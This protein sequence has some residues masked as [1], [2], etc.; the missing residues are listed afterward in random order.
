MSTDQ[1][2]IDDLCINTI[3]MLSVDAIEK[4]KSG[5]P[6]LPMGSAPMAYVLWTRHLRHNPANSKWPNRDRFV[7]SGGHGSMLLYSLLFLTG[8]DLPLA[9]IK[10]FRQWDSRTPG[11]PEMDTVGC[12]IEVTTGPLGQGLSNAV[13]LAIGEAHLAARFNREG[14]PL[15]DHY[16]YVLAS[17]GD[18]MEGVASEACSLAGHLGLGKLIVLYDDNRISLAGSTDLAFTEDTGKRFESYGWHV[19]HVGDGNDTAAIDAA[20]TA[21]KA[22]S[23]KPS[24]ILVH[25]IIGYGAPHKQGT[26]EAH[27]SPLGPKETEETK[28]ALGWPG[29][30]FFVPDEALN[31]FRQTLARGKQQE[32]QW[33]NLKSRYEAAFPEAADEYKRRIADILPDGWEQGLSAF[34]PG[35]SVATRKASEEILQILGKNVPELIGGTADLNNS[36]FAWIKGAGD[37]Q[38]PGTKAEHVQGA[39]GGPWGYDGRNIHFGVREHAMGSIANGIAAHGGLRPFTG[40]FFVFSDYMRPPMR[41]AALSGLNVIFIFSHD[42]I[43]VGEDGP[44]HQPIEQLMNLRAV[45]N[46]A[47]IRPADANETIAAWKVALQ[48]RGPVVFVFSRQ[49]LPILDPARYPVVEGVP[50]GAYVLVDGG[51]HPDLILIASGSEVQLVLRAADEL[52]ARK[53]KARVVSMPSWTLF[54]EQGQGYRD[55][56]LP[57]SVRK[58]LAVEAGATLG[59][60]RWVGDEGDVIGMDHFGASAPGDLLMEK[61]GFT[62][63]NVVARSLKLLGRE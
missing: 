19:Q 4:A 26:F 47:M 63:E 58:R 42:S 30:P 9:E 54:K 17:D 34:A 31:V 12:C 49:N 29:E 50:K 44:T 53:V 37:F 3:R 46:L 39:V 28:K 55:A 21:A 1:K 40:T 13:G 51:D 11:H 23:A 35:K 27:G 60:W 61:F 25:T 48:R 6:G 20:I 18:I 43:G 8:Y 38:K 36:T 59:W 45:P 62:V 14:Y 32:G 15:V 52:A 24:L 2:R 5:H 33:L 57:P 22:E 7:L 56:V 10:N 16:T 41:L